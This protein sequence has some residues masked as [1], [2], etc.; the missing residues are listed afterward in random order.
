MCSSR[1]KCGCNWHC[2]C[3]GGG[4]H[5]T[6]IFL[7]WFEKVTELVTKESSKELARSYED[8]HLSLLSSTLNITLP[9]VHKLDSVAH[10]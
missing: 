9:N 6:I 2:I 4:A 8:A 1:N 5:K 7:T 3:C 10:Q